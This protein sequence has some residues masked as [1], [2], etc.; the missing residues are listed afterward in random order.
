MNTILV[1]EDQALMRRNIATI[2]GMEGYRVL[3]AAEGS[4][5][6]R[7]AGEE[8]PDLVL[9]D[10]MMPG[11]DGYEVLRALRGRRATAMIPFVF[12]TARGEK[13]DQRTGMNL[14]ADDYIVKP[15][16]RL[17]LLDT[18]RTRLERQASHDR[19]LQDE[20]GRIGGDA[21]FTSATPLAE[22]WGLT[23]LQAEILLGIARNL[24]DEEIAGALGIEPRAI[25][26]QLGLIFDRLDVDHRAAAAARAREVLERA[27][28]E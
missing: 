7:I 25:R 8:L 22:R 23:P 5:G 28:L 9:C 10:I 2:L 17:E 4:E 6:L 1:I 12:L 19:R 15:V 11:C 3:T 21:D 16:P 14:G 24:S 13:A 20:L 27:P 18:V 26:P